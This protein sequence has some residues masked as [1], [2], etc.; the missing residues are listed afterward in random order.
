MCPEENAVKR[1]NFTNRQDEND[2]LRVVEHKEEGL[3]SVRTD[4]TSAKDVGTRSK[5]HF[6]I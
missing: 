5:I 2:T 3:A 1:S 4:D 6:V